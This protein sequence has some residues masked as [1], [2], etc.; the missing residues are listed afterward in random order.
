VRSQRYGYVSFT[1]L[2]VHFADVPRGHDLHITEVGIDQHAIRIEYRFTPALKRPGG[3]PAINWTW[4]GYDD[5][6]NVY[7]ESGGAYGVSQDGQATDGV[8]S[9]TPYPFIKQPHTSPCLG[10]SGGI[11]ER[12]TLVQLRGGSQR[13]A[14]ICPVSDAHPCPGE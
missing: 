10:A 9:L 12:P 14:A 7:G 13:A 11:R 4:Q 8:L 2:D 3:R 1:P 6:G 5:L